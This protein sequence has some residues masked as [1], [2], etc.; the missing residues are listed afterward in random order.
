MPGRSAW[1]R[2]KS[3]RL[4]QVLLVY[5]GVSWVVVQVVSDLRDMLML[6]AWIGPVTI[7]LL[8]IGLIIMLATAWVQSSPATD[9][10]ERADEVPGSWELDLGDALR[11]V[12]HGRLPHLTWTRAL[13]GGVAAFLLLFGIGGLYVLTRG[14]AGLFRAS[15]ASASAAPDGIAV[16][17]FT[18]SGDGI[19]AWREGMVDLLATGLDG[20][21]G[22]RS[23]ASRSVLARWHESV[24]AGG[25]VDE[26]V[27][28]DI[29]R[30]LGARYA[31]VG[32][33][34]AIGP[35]VRL[36]AQVH[37]LLPD[38]S[39]RLGV[40]QAE[41]HPDSVLV[42]V[43]RL[44]QQA[45]ARI[46]SGTD[47]DLPRLD[48]ASITTA[49]LPALKSYLEGEALFRRGDFEGAAQAYEDAIAAD[50]LFALAYWRLSQA[51]GW[52]ETIAT[53]RG[54]DAN[55]RALELIDRLPPREALLV[56]ATRFT[57][58]GDT[59]SVALLREA[60][61]RYPDDAEAWYQLGDAYFHVASVLAGWEEAEEA[62][63]RAVALAPRMAPYRM[64]LLDGAFRQHADSALVREQLVELQRLA[65]D[66]PQTHRY[67]LAARLA[68]TDTAALDNT[69]ADVLEMLN[70]PNAGRQVSL[71]LDHP[72]LFE[73]NRRFGE[74]AARRAGRD[75]QR[76]IAMGMGAG[77]FF[78]RGQLK[79]LLATW[80]AAGADPRQGHAFVIGVY[81]SG[82]PVPLDRAEAA[83]AA[84]R[85]RLACRP[86]RGCWRSRPSRPT[87]A[88]GTSSTPASRRSGRTRTRSRRPATRWRRAARAARCGRPR[89]SVPGGAA[90]LM[91]RCGRSMTPASSRPTRWR[92]GTPACC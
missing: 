57:R 51:L 75:I 77:Y 67:A 32:S 78:A 84:L 35:S 52:N 90:A 49:S 17:P 5:L 13:V 43:D 70:A 27:A 80:D 83:A 2:L 72:R 24:P 19:D 10:R 73:R 59:A 34:V 31:L 39:T 55:E 92:H 38:G 42:L 85:V 26:R 74:A 41:G 65:P 44:G 4:A 58:L 69:V 1:S 54:R 64:H 63:R 11:S 30:R 76:Q 89:H 8:G 40:A 45:L 87:A 28:L 68:F 66:A 91:T 21:A 48:L 81:L 53:P 62:F 46:L 20:A 88:A 15:E 18:I 50:S 60:V 61:R 9:A 14:G 82:L 37:E 16:L 33:A 12:R 56:R 3:S 47:A 6:P 71:T 79:H 29:A 36:S 22:L 86:T 25:D 7:I 23:I